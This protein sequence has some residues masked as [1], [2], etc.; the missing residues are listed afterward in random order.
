MA[1]NP[2]SSGIQPVRPPI[3]GHVGPPP[4]PTPPMSMQFR[5]VVLP[6]PPSF[7]PVAPPQFQ[8]GGHSNMGIPPHPQYPQALPPQQLH[9]PPH[10]RPG[11]GQGPSLPQPDF[12]SA[13]P[14]MSA[15]VQQQMSNNF[16]PSYGTPGT[17]HV[18]Y[19]VLS[20]SGGQQQMNVVPIAQQLPLPQ[21]DASNFGQPW[22][23]TG[24]QNVQSVM[25][26][27]LVAE[28]SGGEQAWL[29]SG[30]QSIKPVTPMQQSGEQNH[31]GTQQWLPGGDQKAELCDSRQ[32]GEKIAAMGKNTSPDLAIKVPSDWKEHTTREGKKYYYNKRTKI[33][34]WEKPFELMSPTERADAST[35]WREFIAPDGRR[36][37]HNKVTKQSKWLI[38]DVVKLARE[39]LN[40]APCEGIPAGND[41]NSSGL[42]ALASVRNNSF[43]SPPEMASSPVSV[44]PSGNQDGSSSTRDEVDNS[45]PDTSEMKTPRE[46]TYSLVKSGTPV[47]ITTPM[48]AIFFY[49]L[50]YEA[51]NAFKALLESANV[52]SDWNW[53]QQAM[54]VI[55]NDRRYG[56]LRTLG[57]RK[58]A[59][60]EFVGQKK[61]QEAEEKRARN[62]KSREDFMTMLRESMELTSS[63]KWSQAVIMFENDERFQA[64]ER[65]IDREDLFKDHLEEL[66]KMERAKALEEHKRH[67]AEYLEFLKSCD[68]IKACF[69]WRKVQHRLEGDERCSRLEKMECLEIFQ[70]YIRELEMH[71]EED[72]KLQIEELRKIER[73]NRDE[74]R[75]LMEEHAASGILTHQT[76]WRDYS[77]KVKD[78]PAYV[79]VSSNTSG[80]TAKDLF[81]DVV[82]DLEK[83]FLEDKE[84]IEEAIKN[85]K[86]SLLTTWSLEDFKSALS[87][88]KNTSTKPISDV[89]LKLVLDE[90]LVIT[91]G[92]EEKEAMKRKRLAENVHAFLFSLKEISS[93]SKW[94]DCKSLIEG[95]FNGQES[96]FRDIFDKFILELKEK[97]KEKE[98]R[99]K[100]EKAKKERER[101]RREKKEKDRRNKDRGSHERRKERERH[102]TDETD[103]DG[104]GSHDLE[105]SK[106]SR[107]RSSR[108]HH[109]KHVRTL[110]DTSFDDDDD[111]ERSRSRRQSVDSK[112]S[113]QMDKDAETGSESQIKRH[114]RDHRDALVKITEH[115]ESKD[116]EID[117]DV[118][119][120]LCKFLIWVEPSLC[121]RATKIISSGS[122]GLV[123]GMHGLEDSACPCGRASTLGRELEIVLR[124][125]L[126]RSGSCI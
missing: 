51:K 122:V 105:D 32:T 3:I 111:K 34:S 104:S 59:F 31:A 87:L 2:P 121:A 86:I 66:K 28:Q 24:N 118:E 48:Y 106:R 91:K 99:R 45:K 120:K 5:P 29:S 33:S 10:Q 114:K 83:Q 69:Q 101:S 40:A 63:T 62:K 38:P 64:V 52:A 100:E 8:T 116:G 14:M 119:G 11:P 112:R 107:E 54:K 80:S 42:E 85:K 68:F 98:R 7:V 19:T 58:Q 108:R 25:S 75:K 71:E 126:V 23:S 79:A 81:D 13:R 43:L 88:S 22:F 16:V 27:P 26:V 109:R 117:E 95:R 89:T 1:N 21:T 96:F 60:N 36:F 20:S 92:K 90:L 73:K 9:P 18:T 93:S 76:L 50:I 6:P 35:D 84:S 17:S 74:F 56:A 70:E 110:D 77:T 4:N 30:P 57:E 115:D 124:E 82:E 47:P 102:K 53:D 41:V 67:K 44:T 94:E 15:H 103:S 37:Y 113:K 39:R 65:V 123:D 125:S 12:Q 61:K 78:N 97:A 72:R 46:T 49:K 55:I